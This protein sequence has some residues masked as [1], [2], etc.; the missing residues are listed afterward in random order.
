MDDGMTQKAKVGRPSVYDPAFCDA[1]V[2]YLSNG[3]S[4]TALAGHLRVARTTIYRWADENDEFRDALRAGQA[5][6]VEWWENRLRD[7][8]EGKDG[9]ATAAIFALKNRGQEDWR[10]KQTF[11]IERPIADMTDEELATHVARLQS[12]IAVDE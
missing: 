2:E 10:E 7:I 4:T 6:G 12:Q 8:G 5:A 11:E 3:Y 1:A 9:N